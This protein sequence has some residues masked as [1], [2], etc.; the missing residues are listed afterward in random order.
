[1]QWCEQHQVD[2]VLGLARNSRLEAEVAGEL[3]AAEVQS[4]TS[5][6]PVRLFKDFTYR[7]RE[8]WSR[9]RRVVGK[10]E[11]LTDKANPR[12]VVTSYPAQRMAAAPL[13]EEL[14]CARGD[15]ENRI[16]EQQLGLFADRTSS[17]TM[18]ANQLR[19]WFAAVAYLLV[20][21]LRHGGLRDTEL[22][23][24]QVS[25]IRCRLLKL[26]ARITVS[27]RRV[28]ASLS[29]AFPWQT[30]FAQVLA[31]LQRTYPLRL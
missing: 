1:M 15:M 21:H 29:S 22:A 19:L 6:K 23:R 4:R 7:T 16:K 18:R 13:Y 28:V 24:A 3:A 17:A 12:F 31:N 14:Y 25:T 10:A 30:L 9:S 5:G 2:Y 26:G 8:S 11:Y 27:A 20:N